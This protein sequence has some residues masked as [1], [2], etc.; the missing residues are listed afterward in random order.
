MSIALLRVAACLAYGPL[1]L[2]LGLYLLALALRS[3][4]RPA[5]LAFLVKSTSEHPPVPR[6]H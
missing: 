5:L 3:C 2:M 4:R 6:P 1:L